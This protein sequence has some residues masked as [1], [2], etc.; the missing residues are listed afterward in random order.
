MAISLFKKKKNIETHYSSK[1]IDETNALYRVIIGMRSN[2]KTYNYLTKV[3][4][5]FF[6]E[7]LPSAYIRRYSEEIK[8]RNLSSLFNPF[9]EEIKKRSKRQKRW[10]K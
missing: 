4:D 5:A 9:M 7:N 3:I 6:E 10:S 8:T 2:G 1:D